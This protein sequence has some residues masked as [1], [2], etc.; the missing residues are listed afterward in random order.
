[1]NVFHTGSRGWRWKLESLLQRLELL[2]QFF[3][4]CLLGRGVTGVRRRALAEECAGGV[5]NFTKSRK[6]PTPSPTPKGRQT[7]I[8]LKA[9]SPPPVMGV[10]IKDPSPDS[11]KPTQDEVSSKGKENAVEPPP[12]V[13]S[14]SKLALFSS[15]V[16]QLGSSLGEKRPSLDSRSSPA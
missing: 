15:K 4:L 6:N 5:I 1:M 8:S 3:L 16:A 9:K 13:K 11:V 14:T 12:N 7:K 2:G 10:V